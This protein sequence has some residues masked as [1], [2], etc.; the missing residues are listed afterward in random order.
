MAEAKKATS[1]DRDTE[2][3]RCKGSVVV[4]RSQEMA[5]NKLTFTQ[6]VS[7]PILG[8]KAAYLVPNCNPDPMLGLVAS[9][10]DSIGK[11]LEWEVRVWSN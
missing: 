6:E 11:V 3:W 10:E 1:A 7:K 2:L 8:R 9:G 5:N 4:L